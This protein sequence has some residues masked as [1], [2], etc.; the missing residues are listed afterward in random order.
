MLNK[1]N[2]LFKSLWFFRSQYDYRKLSH[3][4]KQD[5]DKNSSQIL[6]VKNRSSK[7][8]YISSTDQATNSIP[9]NSAPPLEELVGNMKNILQ[10][11]GLPFTGHCKTILLT[12]RVCIMHKE[13]SRIEK[14]ELGW[15]DLCWNF[16]LVA[17]L[18]W[19]F[20]YLLQ[21]LTAA[22]PLKFMCILDS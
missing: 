3:W 14:G 21:F 13:C 2:Q 12:V 11:Q 5:W 8:I 17:S 20:R 18:V 1:S 10:I 7:K 9:A 4:L 15:L 6:S 16:S 22:D 19:V